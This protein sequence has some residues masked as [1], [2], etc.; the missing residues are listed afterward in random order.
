MN[1]PTTPSLE[2]RLKRESL[3]ILLSYCEPLR[4]WYEALGLVKYSSETTS[5]ID[6]FQD[7]VADALVSFITQEIATATANQREELVQKIMGA[8]TKKIP[9]YLNEVEKE[10]YIKIDELNKY[11]ESLREGNK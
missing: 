10:W 3:D 4:S 9:S 6:A 5:K 1:N 7:E 2:E 8:P 11:L